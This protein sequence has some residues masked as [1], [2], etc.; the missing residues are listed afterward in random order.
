MPRSATALVVSEDQQFQIEQWLAALGTP[1]QVALRC[2]IVLAAGCGNTE[3]QIA[4]TLEIN[5]KTVDCGRSVLHGKA[6]RGCGR[7]HRDADASR[8]TAQTVSRRS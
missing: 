5:R 8:S 3:A 1:Q 2:R 4:A 7:L 6:C